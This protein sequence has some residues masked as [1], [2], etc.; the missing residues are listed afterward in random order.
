MFLR[1]TNDNLW[2]QKTQVKAKVNVFTLSD[3]QHTCFPSSV[4]MG[5]YQAHPSCMS[6]SFSHFYMSEFLFPTLEVKNYWRCGNLGSGWKAFPVNR[7][8]FTCVGEEPECFGVDILICISQECHCQWSGHQANGRGGGGQRESP[9]TNVDHQQVK[10]KV[11]AC[12]DTTAPDSF[13]G[14]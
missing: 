6:S 14:F 11:E 8:Y 12:L 3:L 13:S 1:D 5:K 7:N 9:G 10:L 2:Q 4:V